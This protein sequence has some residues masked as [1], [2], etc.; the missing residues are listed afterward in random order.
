MIDLGGI[1]KHELY[2]ETIQEND[3]TSLV[4]HDVIS[5]GLCNYIW[6]EIHMI[7]MSEIKHKIRDAL[8]YESI[9]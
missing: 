6:H 7:S 9:R 3:L 4:K 1:L 2:I 8:P 5:L